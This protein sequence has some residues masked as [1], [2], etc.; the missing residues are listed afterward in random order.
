MFPDRPKAAGKNVQ[1][2]S[3]FYSLLSAVVRLLSEPR[4]G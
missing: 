3:S 4:T 1:L 2:D